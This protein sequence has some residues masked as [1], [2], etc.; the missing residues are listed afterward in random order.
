MNKELEK[1]KETLEEKKRLVAKYE[2]D[3]CLKFLPIIHIWMGNR[4]L[5]PADQA[6]LDYA[7]YP[8]RIIGEKEWDRFGQRFSRFNLAGIFKAD[9]LRLLYLY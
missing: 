7:D 4:T 1:K 8:Y 6:S 3:N 9:I 2:S 5:N